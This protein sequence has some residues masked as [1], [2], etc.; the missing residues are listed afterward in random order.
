MSTP[1]Y[2]HVVPPPPLPPGWTEHIGIGFRSFSRVHSLSSLSARRP[3]VLLQRTNPGFDLHP[4]PTS[5]S[6]PPRCSATTCRSEER[7][8]THQDTHPG[9]G[10][11]SGQDNRGQYILLE[12]SHKAESMDCTLRNTPASRSFGTRTR[13]FSKTSCTWR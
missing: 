4:S 3:A 7:K 12:Q 1:T 5:V 10:L 11:A 2:P 8:A 13:I 9:V 6:V